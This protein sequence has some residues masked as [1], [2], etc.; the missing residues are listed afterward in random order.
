MVHVRD[1][2]VLFWPM[3]QTSDLLGHQHE[4]EDANTYHQGLHTSKHLV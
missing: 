2:I 3:I 1:R 4:D